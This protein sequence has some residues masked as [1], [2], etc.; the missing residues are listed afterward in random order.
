[1]AAFIG[2]LSAAT[3]MVIVE[4]V[5]LSIM[6]SND[7][8]IPLFVRRLLR[9]STS[10]NEDWSTLILNVRR[11]AIFI[12]LFIAFL[13]YRESTNSARLSSIGLMSFAAIAQFAPALIGGLIWRGAKGRGAA[14]CM[15][16]GILVWAYT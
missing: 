3:A 7:L 4:S 16:A 10:E 5:A 2:G 6:I 9:T 12:M 11:G 1:M 8:V 14:L 13:Y 15:V